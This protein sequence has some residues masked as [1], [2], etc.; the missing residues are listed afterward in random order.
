MVNNA[1]RIGHLTSSEIVNLFSRGKREMTAE[2]LA[3]RP[4]SGKGSSVK[5]IEEGFGDGALTYIA[6]KR[7]ERRLGRGLNDVG[8]AKPMLW[9]KNAEKVCFD[10]L[11][12]EYQLSSLET[13]EHPEYTW[14]AGSPDGRNEDAVLEIKCPFTVYSFC[15]FADCK[16]ISEIREKHPDGEKYYWQCV[17]NS[18]LLDL[19][20]SELIIYCPYKSELNLVREEAENAWNLNKVAWIALSDDEDLPYIPDNGH[21]KNL[22]KFRF[23]I[24]K[25]DKE[26]LTNL[27]IEAGKILNA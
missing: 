18:I 8:T 7:M 16:D 24:P 25:S 26:L 4:K 13:I 20:Y 19:N 2:E 22:Y 15:T 10:L 12:K 5:Y 11:G 27:I 23:E 17:G 9:G 3:L 14:F 6:K 21:Y 1:N